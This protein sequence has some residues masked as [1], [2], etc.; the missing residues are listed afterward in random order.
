MT[1]TSA[2]FVVTRKKTKGERPKKL[3]ALLEALAQESGERVTLGEIANE[4]AHRSFGAFLV[5]FC[6]PN[7]IPMPPGAT[8]ILGIPLILIAWQIIFSRQSH[9]WMPKRLQ[10][11]SFSRESF[12]RGMTK[13]GPWLAWA[14]TFVK[15]RYWGLTTRTAERWFGIFCLTLAVL[16]FLPIPFGNWLPALALAIIG[17]ALSERD[18]LSLLIGV[19]TGVTSFILATAVVIASAAMVHG[20]LHALLN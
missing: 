19:A 6:I 1:D 3:S 5:V 12:A 17:F 18:G 13:V 11:V 4:M 16:V 20:F 7:L 2:D 9:V 8:L 14:E 15:P 10:A